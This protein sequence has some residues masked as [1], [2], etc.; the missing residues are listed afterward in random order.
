MSNVLLEASLFP[1]ETSFRPLTDH[2][3]LEPLEQKESRSSGGILIPVTAAGPSN[4]YVQFRVI[5]AGPHCSE[6]KFSEFPRPSISAGQT[7]LVPTEKALSCRVEGREYYI[8][9]YGDVAAV[10]DRG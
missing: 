1:E 4:K 2:I 5:A 3:I 10:V 9:R 6:E 7:V 8:A